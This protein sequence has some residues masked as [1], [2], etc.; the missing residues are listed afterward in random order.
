M[1]EVIYPLENG[2]SV[3]LDLR[4]PYLAAALGWLWPGAGH[5]YQRRY[6]KGMLFMVCV[7]STYFFGLGIGHGR[8][9]YASFKPEGSAYRWQYLLQLQV[10]IPALPAI[11]QNFKTRDGGDPF[12]VLCERYPADYGENERDALKFSRRFQRI[13]PDQKI[14]GALKD[15]LMAP[16]AG[17]FTEERNDVL[18]QWHYELKHLFD[19]GTYYTV[20]A[21]LLNLLIVYDAFVGPAIH[22][23]IK[24]AT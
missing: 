10:G 1:T 5:L 24:K 18:G 23:P 7:L 17:A 19:L 21:G 13:P 6:A 16:P 15:G 12:I 8:V 2:E 22:P 4:S 3:R 20:I 11:V 9:V 14:D